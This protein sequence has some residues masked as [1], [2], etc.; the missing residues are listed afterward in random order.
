M[1]PPINTATYTKKVAEFSKNSPPGIL[2]VGYPVFVPE[3]NLANPEDLSP[4]KMLPDPAN[5]PIPLRQS[6]ASALPPFMPIEVNEKIKNET[7]VRIITVTE[8]F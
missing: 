8:I 6:P 7:E 5:F 3:E 1:L 4:L 2:P